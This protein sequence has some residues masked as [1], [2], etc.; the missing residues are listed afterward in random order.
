MWVSSAIRW[1][2]VPL[3]IFASLKVILMPSLLIK[4][5]FL[6]PLPLIKLLTHWP[7]HLVT[8]H[9]VSLFNTQFF[10]LLVQTEW[11]EH[12]QILMF[13][14]KEQIETWTNS[15]PACVVKC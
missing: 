15:F 2:L 7:S 11:I 3:T 13:F 12:P 1:L 5:A 9:R 14:V 6:P 10:G 4:L 8:T